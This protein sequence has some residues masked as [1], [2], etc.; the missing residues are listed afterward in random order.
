[1]TQVPAFAAAWHSRLP[2]RCAL[3]L[4]ATAPSAASNQA[5]TVPSPLARTADLHFKTKGYAGLVRASDNSAGRGF[6]KTCGSLLFWKGDASPT[7]SVA[8]GSLN[9]KTGLK[10][11]GHIYCADKGDYYEIH[12]GEYQTA[13]VVS[14]GRIRPASPSR[15]PTHRNP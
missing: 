8:A 13:T 3:S 9:G 14:G 15:W 11:E 12:D 7:I 4:L 1:M 2:D 5:I 6:C 10:T